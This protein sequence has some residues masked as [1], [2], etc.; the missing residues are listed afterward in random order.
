LDHF[1]IVDP[2]IAPSDRFF[3]VWKHYGLTE[4]A[5]TKSVMT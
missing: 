1:G 3:E 4:E 2:Q 5:I